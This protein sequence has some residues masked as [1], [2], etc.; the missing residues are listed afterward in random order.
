[1][2]PECLMNCG[3]GMLKR[4]RSMGSK[5]IVA[6]LLLSPT[7]AGCGSETLEGAVATTATAIRTTPAHSSAR[8]L[9][10]PSP[11]PGITENI[12][13]AR[14]ECGVAELECEGRCA[15]VVSDRNNCGQCGLR[16]PTNGRCE[17]ARCVVDRSFGRLGGARPRRL[18]PHETDSVC[19]AP[20]VN[21]GDRCVDLTS[22]SRACGSCSTA[23]SLGSR[24][25]AGRCVEGPRRPS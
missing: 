17:N 24:C 13:R 18:E 5:G 1:M 9:R 11:E 19:P 16:C 2:N 4:G 23:C 15:A 22:D 12:H 8:G 14:V 25:Y 7:L 10:P 3:A 20:W 21:C 6:A